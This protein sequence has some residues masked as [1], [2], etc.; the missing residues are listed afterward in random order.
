MVGPD[1]QA[2]WPLGLLEGGQEGLVESVLYI[3]PT[4][5]LYFVARM[6]CLHCSNTVLEKRLC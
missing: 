1:A 5:V 6:W 2:W 3:F 4:Q